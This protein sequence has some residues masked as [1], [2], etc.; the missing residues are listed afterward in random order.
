MPSKQTISLIKKLS[1]ASV[2]EEKQAFIAEGYK[3]IS[4]LLPYFKCLHIILDINSLHKIEEKLKNSIDSYIN[5]N[6]VE[7]VDSSFNF[8]RISNNKTPQKAIAIFKKTINH[9]IVKYDSDDVCLYLENIQDPGNM[10]TIIR[11]ADWFAV[12]TIYL[13]HDCVDI[14]NPK[15]VQSTMGSLGRINFQKISNP[16]SLLKNNEFDI[17]GT[18]LTGESIYS[19]EKKHKKPTLIIMG[20]E[21][22]GISDSTAKYVNRKITIPIFK[23]QNSDQKHP[24][25][26][27][28]A[29]ATAIVLSHIR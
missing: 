12:N 24:D 1:I 11:T 4:G 28:V 6:V 27:N 3:C 21:G 13:S 9:D 7:I 16:E 19:F 8:K 5:E 18:F 10:G 22:N 29:I 17:I 25:S 15:V 23:K 14:Y 26:L 2:R 20:N